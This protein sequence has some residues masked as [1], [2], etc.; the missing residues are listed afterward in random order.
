MTHPIPEFTSKR[1]GVTKAD[2]HPFKMDGELYTM[3]TP[4]TAIAVS[5]MRLAEAGE[6]RDASEVGMDMIRLVMQILSYV[7]E[8]KPDKDGALRGRERLEQRLTDPQDG[9]DIED[10]TTVFAQLAKVMFDRP[11][12]ASPVPSTRRRGKAS[13]G[14]GAGT[15]STRAAKSGTSTAASF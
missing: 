13:P 14:S 10:L 11:T 15:P 12:G 7:E 3:I 1:R 8:E 5:M 2:K 9:F 6:D 4:K